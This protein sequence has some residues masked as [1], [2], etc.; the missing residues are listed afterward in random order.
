MLKI[1]Y[2]LVLLGYECHEINLFYK[3]T[4]L[5]CEGIASTACRDIVSLCE[6]V[7]NSEKYIADII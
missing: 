7:L 2:L 5:F 6:G 3:D 1:K 4:G